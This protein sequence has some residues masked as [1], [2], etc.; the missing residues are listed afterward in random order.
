MAEITWRRSEE[1][2][3]TGCCP[4]WWGRFTQTLSRAKEGKYELGIEVAEGRLTRG[5]G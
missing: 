1:A 2:G 3:D 4:G 5:Q